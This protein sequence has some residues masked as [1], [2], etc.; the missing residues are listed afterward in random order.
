MKNLIFFSLLLFVLAFPAAAHANIYSKLNKLSNVAYLAGKSIYAKKSDLSEGQAYETCR[1]F[2][3][4]YNKKLVADNGGNK[5]YKQFLYYM[6]PAEITYCWV[7]YL[8]A[9][10][11]NK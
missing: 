1:Y 5:N 9:S 8:D 4:A 10:G 11:P 7:G 6:S 3:L 2:M